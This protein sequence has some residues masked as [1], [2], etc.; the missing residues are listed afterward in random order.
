MILDRIREYARTGDMVIRTK[1]EY[2]LLYQSDE[3]K[4][5]NRAIIPRTL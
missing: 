5:N 2:D 3:M 1:G 4:K